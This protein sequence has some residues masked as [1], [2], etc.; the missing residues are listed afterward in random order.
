MAKQFVA[1]TVSTPWP[2]RVL[3]HGAYKFTRPPT[4]DILAINRIKAIPAAF[5]IRTW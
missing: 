3:G 1:D 4:G 2:L 5:P